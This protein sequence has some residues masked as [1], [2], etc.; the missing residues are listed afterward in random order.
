MSK[1]QV[2]K[3]KLGVEINICNDILGNKSLKLSKERKLKWKEMHGNIILKLSKK[4]D[5]EK[6]SK[7]APKYIT[8]P[9]TASMA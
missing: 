3:V 9:H 1:V 7:T 2:P 8:L 5:L 6:K 4:N